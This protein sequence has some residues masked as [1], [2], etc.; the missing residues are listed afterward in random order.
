[1]LIRFCFFTLSGELA[2]HDV[3]ALIFIL[4]LPYESYFPSSVCS[5]SFYACLVHMSD[6]SLSQLLR[7]FFEDKV[8]FLRVTSM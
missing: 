4:L 6:I 8:Q 5:I 2:T 3:C 7:K 1:M